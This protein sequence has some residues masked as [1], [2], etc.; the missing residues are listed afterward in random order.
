MLIAFLQS[1]VLSGATVHTLVP[2]E[3]PRALL[4]QDGKIA[5]VAAP[6]AT[7]AFPK[8]ARRV[9]VSGLHA[10]PGL[11]DALV[12]HDP[13]HDR[14]Y[15]A[16]GVTLV[17]DQGGDLSPALAER[18]LAARDR[19]PGPA[20]WTAGAPLTGPSA[21][22]GIVLE[23][24]D[25]AKEKVARLLGE[26][27]LDWLAVGPEL[28]TGAWKAAL[29]LAHD[30]ELRV[31]GP[32][33]QSSSLAEAIDARQ[34]GV[35]HVDAL[36][37]PGKAWNEVAFVDLLPRVEKLAASKT[38]LVPT[39]ALHAAQVLQ[40][41]ADAPELPHLGP[42]YVQ[43]WIADAEQRRRV[44]T[45][46]NGLELQKAGVAALGLQQELVKAVWERKG[47]L[48]P[49]SAS[50][51]PWLFPGRALVEE[52][53]LWGRA[54]IAAPDV[55][56]AATSGAAELLGLPD[57]GTIA[58]GKI[59]DLVFYA[60]DPERELATLRD[61]RLVVLRGRVFDRAALDELVLDLKTK[62][63][64][65][66]QRAFG[67][68]ELPLDPPPTPE[69][70]VLARGA[71]VQ[72]VLG[73][74]ATIERWAVVRGADGAFTYAT[75]MRTFGGIAKADTDLVLSQTVRDDR[76][77]QFRL[78]VKS[79][80]LE[81]VTKGLAVANVFNVER[82]ANGQFVGN[83]PVKDKLVLVDVG[84]VLAPLQAA[85]HAREGNFKALFF[86]DYE[87]AVG[88]WE[89]RVDDKGT[90]LLRTHSGFLAAS[91]GADGV[92][93]QV[94]REQGRGI[95]EFEFAGNELPAGPWP[96][97]AENRIPSKPAAQ[98]R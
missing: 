98:P 50:P 81:V 8:D 41:K 26:S 56:R 88:P 23:S 55:V 2:G 24:A 10:L 6:G 40:P 43:L 39:L 83:V 37:P 92:P 93:T 68:D 49:G 30:R 36:L 74:R 35:Y 57:R 42:L 5:A 20:L 33:L 21:R 4:V 61:P 80:P 82:R 73:M 95:A 96:I 86:D 63:V 72:R 59:A 46:E 58:P 79:G 65:A 84:S 97:P 29:E 12:N 62:Q 90:L 22:Y 16:A 77:V 11:V 87:P 32:V 69:G 28:G 71:V 48:V 94:R 1:V 45:G 66:Q 13:E 31:F 70:V 91:I 3:S 47:R 27:H 85:H 25:A 17:C 89:F 54:G 78:T 38:A 64:A 53:V 15:V 60:G 7:A 18:L 19:N 14:L 34:D 75:H 9:D 44:F 67:K 51:R 52:L 76:L